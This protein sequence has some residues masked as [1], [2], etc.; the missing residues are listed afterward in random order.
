MVG[1]RMARSLEPTRPDF[2]ATAPYSRPPTVFVRPPTIPPRSPGDVVV[3]VDVL[4]VEEPPT[5]VVPAPDPVAVVPPVETEPEPD[6]EVVPVEPEPVV[7]DV[8]PVGGVVAGRVVEPVGVVEF[9][10]VD[11]VP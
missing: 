8:V 1:I 5:V 7:P 2:G 6:T 10:P 11:G 9:V 4:E 3:V